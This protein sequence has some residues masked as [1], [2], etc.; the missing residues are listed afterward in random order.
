MIVLEIANYLPDAFVAG[1][2]YMIRARAVGGALAANVKGLDHSGLKPLL[3]AAPTTIR[4]FRGR[5]SGP[6]FHRYR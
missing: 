2:D 3:H 6:V 5:P 1:K 4:E